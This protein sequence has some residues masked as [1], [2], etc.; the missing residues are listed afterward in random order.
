MDL[1]EYEH[2]YLNCKLWG[3]LQQLEDSSLKSLG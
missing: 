1:N 3:L 2:K